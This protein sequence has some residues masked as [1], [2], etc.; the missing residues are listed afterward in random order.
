[1]SGQIARLVVGTFQESARAHPPGAACLS[2]AERQVLQLLACGLLY[3]EVADQMGISQGTVRTHI[4]HI[5]RKLHANNRTE[6]ILKGLRDRH[7][8]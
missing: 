2:P 8:R 3:K 5:Y 4:F 7:L 6:A 1:M